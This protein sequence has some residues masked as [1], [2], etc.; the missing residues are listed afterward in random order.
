ML[1]INNGEIEVDVDSHFRGL[2]PLNCALNPSLEYVALV[3][4]VPIC[5]SMHTIWKA[6]ILFYS[7]A[8]LLFPGLQ[9]MPSAP[10][11]HARME[12]C[13]LR[14]IIPAD[15]PHAGILTYGYDT[16]LV[17]SK[18]NA[19]I[20]DFAKEFLSAIIDARRGDPHRPFIFIGHSLGGLLI[21]EVGMIHFQS[22]LSVKKHHQFYRSLRIGRTSEWL[23]AKE[24]FGTTRISRP[25]CVTRLQFPSTHLGEWSIFTRYATR[26][27]IRHLR[28][29]GK[30]SNV[31]AG[32]W[33]EFFS[34]YWLCEV[35]SHNFNVPP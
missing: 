27:W 17:G 5:F 35:A 11:D 20:S 6:D 13:G 18:S 8:S 15:L 23:R 22:R 2:I 7:L 24:R 1:E 26:F 29:T 28:L 9:V 30:G 21:K 4:L 32:L 10:G 25:F 33:K 3:S 34:N 16:K 14:D 19:R 31:L 12:R